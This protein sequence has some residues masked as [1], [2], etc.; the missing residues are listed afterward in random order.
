MNEMKKNKA[1]GPDGIT[2]EQLTA[3]D[4]FGI[5]KTTEIMN[6]MRDSGEIPEDM[7]RSIFLA[8][9]KKP[10]AINCEPHRTISLVSHMTKILLCVLM[11]RAR[12]KIKPEI[13]PEQ[14]G[15]MQDTDTRNAIFI[16]RM[17]PERVLEVQKDLYICYIDYTKAFD[18]VKYEQL[19]D[20]L[21]NLDLDGK[22]LKVMRNLY[23]EQSACIRIGNDYS[24]YKMIQRGVRQGCVFS[25]DLFN[26]YSET[27]MGE[28]EE[29]EGLIVGGRKIQI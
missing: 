20:I 22:D 27:I 29:L 9:P 25:P 18:K 8:L 7:A 12:N 19:F 1:A 2:V 13:G 23:W 10:G 5:D 11:N 6:Q 3:P 28:L 26:I 16:I 21:E 17:L 24:Q 15:L 4:E 14:C